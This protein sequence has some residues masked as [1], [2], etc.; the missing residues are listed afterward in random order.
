MIFTLETNKM[1]NIYF[2]T[3]TTKW[4]WEKQKRSDT[5]QERFIAQYLFI[6]N[7]V[8]VSLFIEWRGA[9]ALGKRSGCFMIIR[10]PNS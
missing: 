6:A 8:R 1:V 5:V 3:K 10:W 9:E 4:R 2:N 7:S